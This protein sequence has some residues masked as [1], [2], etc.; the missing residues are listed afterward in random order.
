LLERVFSDEEAL[1][2]RGGTP[3]LKSAKTLIHYDGERFPF[4]DGAFDYVICS[5]VLEHVEDIEQFC[6]EL[7][8]VAP[9]GYVEF[10]TV[11][12][13]YLYNFSVHTQLLNFSDKRLIY[14]PKV[15]SGLAAFQPLQNHY[16]RS[17]ELGYS[18]LVQDLKPLMFQGIEWNQSFEIIKASSIADL[19]PS[20]CNLQAPRLHSLLIRKILRWFR[21]I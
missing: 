21:I 19:V 2:Q 3:A 6:S 4:E 14:L 18:D 20:S 10:P 1:K 17:L 16:N 13:E 11:Y 7:F 15:D 5:H 9:K 8:R 12:Y